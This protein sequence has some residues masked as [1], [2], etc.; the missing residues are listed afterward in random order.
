MQ[1]VP[2]LLI[3]VSLFIVR[4]VSGELVHKSGPLEG[5][6]VQIRSRAGLDIQIRVGAM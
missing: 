5:A 2:S 3:G 6:A 1:S 4:P